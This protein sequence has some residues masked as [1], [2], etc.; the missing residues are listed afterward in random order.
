MREI[1]GAVMTNDGTE[2]L[3]RSQR[4]R[5]ASSKPSDAGDGPRIATKQKKKGR[6]STS[7]VCAQ[8]R[9]A[10]AAAEATKPAQSTDTV[11]PSKH[12]QSSPKAAELPRVAD[13]TAVAEDYGHPA[14][15][16]HDKC[17]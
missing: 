15:T 16:E 5:R 4:K 8:K 6:S 17:S 12:V 14:R 7:K 1:Y 2:S 11:S 13:D 10:Q 9:R 3:R